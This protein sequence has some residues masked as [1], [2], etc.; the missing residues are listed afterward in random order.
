[1]WLRWL[2]FENPVTREG[3]SLRIDRYRHGSRAPFVAVYEG[4]QMSAEVGPH[5]IRCDSEEAAEAVFHAEFE[6]LVRKG[7]ALG[8]RPVGAPR[9]VPSVDG[10]GVRR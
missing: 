7:C 6:R 8:D 10:T 1:M 4:S 5:I 2:R 9:W 3:A